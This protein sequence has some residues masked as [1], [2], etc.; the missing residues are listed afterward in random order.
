LHSATVNPGRLHQRAV[1]F[2]PSI[3]LLRTLFSLGDRSREGGRRTSRSLTRQKHESVFSGTS[4]RC[5]L[6]RCRCARGGSSQYPPHLSR[7]ANRLQQAECRHCIAGCGLLG[8]ELGTRGCWTR[9]SCTSSSRQKLTG[10]SSNSARR[11]NSRR[12]V[13]GS[14]STNSSEFDSEAKTGRSC[15]L[16]NRAAPTHR[17]NHENSR[18]TTPRTELGF[19]GSRP[20]SRRQDVPSSW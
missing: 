19:Y 11:A 16:S 14:G 20:T 8:S 7:Q 17:A 13:R 1:A 12:E 18:M 10:S 15:G 6:D 2:Q 9:V 5:L 3:L 4:R